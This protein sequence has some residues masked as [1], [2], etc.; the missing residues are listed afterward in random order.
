MF[1]WRQITQQL[2]ANS[3]YLMVKNKHE[4]FFSFSARHDFLIGFHSP[5]VQE[6]QV[7]LEDPGRTYEKNI[8]L[9]N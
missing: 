7:D 3:N 4:L 9:S 6:G 5:L 2:S 1:P 8:E